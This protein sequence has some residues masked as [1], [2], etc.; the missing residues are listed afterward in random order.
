MVSILFSVMV[1][2]S[3][4]YLVDKSVFILWVRVFMFVVVVSHVGMF[5]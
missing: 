1:L 2:V 5:I 4:W 3:G